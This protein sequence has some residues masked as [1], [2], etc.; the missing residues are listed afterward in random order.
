MFRQTINNKM[1]SGM[2]WLKNYVNNGLWVRIP[3]HLHINH[4][5]FISVDLTLFKK[6]HY[7]T[8]WLP[9]IGIDQKLIM[10]S[11]W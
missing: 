6:C 7:F 9:V 10:I 4:I 5:T 2:P 11:R 8:S 1:M 3:K